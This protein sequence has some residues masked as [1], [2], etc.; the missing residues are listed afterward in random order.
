V[1]ANRR[2][3]ELLAPASTFAL[4]DHDLAPFF[5]AS[6]ELPE[7]WRN[8]FGKYDLVLSYLYDPA[9]I[10]EQ[11]VRSCGSGT[12]IAGPHRIR[13][14]THGTD[15]LAR[16]LTQLRIDI[17]DWEPRIELSGGEQEIARRRSE[18]PLVAL[19]PG[20]GS[21]RKNWPIENWIALI[22]ALLLSGKRVCVVGGEADESEI[23]RVRQRFGERLSYAIDWPL[24][25]LAALLGN[26]TFIGHD[27]GTSHLAAATG[28][29][30]LILFGPTEPKVW[31][32]RNGN[33]RVLV[34]P[35][36]DFTQ[37]TPTQVRDELRLL[38][39]SS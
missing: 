17:T 31:A 24:R 39:L 23:A 11:N 27:S 34:A 3:R 37:L 16:P 12:F 2:L 32:P 4:D 1:L 36:G 21:A 38:E 18:Y 14:E 8:C 15:Q 20:S 25:R 22:E 6:G 19:H 9:R 30:C 26:T 7:R 35:G 33:A 5:A 29:R 13:P 28:T 10:F